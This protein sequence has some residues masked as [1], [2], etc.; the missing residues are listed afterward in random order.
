MENVRS[1]GTSYVTSRVSG[2]PAAGSVAYKVPS[3]NAMID[4]W[5]NAAPAGEDRVEAG[6]LFK[7]AQAR[8]CKLLDLSEQRYSSLTSLPPDL[9]DELI[10]LNLG[11]MTNLTALSVKW[12]PN[13]K[14]LYLNNCTGVVSL[15][16]EL[17]ELVFLGLQ[18][19]SSLTSLDNLPATLTHLNLIGCTSLPSV[20]GNLSE[21]MK[22]L[23]PSHL[24]AA[25]K[26]VTPR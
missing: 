6:R 3:Y 5:V 7:Y 18:G 17:P 8:S 16:T 19:C 26:F 12:P 20:P 25:P 21:T 24:T 23:L 9:P 14:C 13:L 15:P 10:E 4:T 22:V 11:N 2:S 1:I